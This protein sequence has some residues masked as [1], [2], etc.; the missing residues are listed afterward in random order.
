M[1][2]NLEKT[3]TTAISKKLV[4]LRNEVGSMT[5]GRVMT[6]V[7]LVDED[8]VDEAVNVA[9]EATRLHPSRIVV[10]VSDPDSSEPMLNAQIRLGGDAGASEIIVMELHGEL[11]EHPAAAL[12]P[13]LLADSPVVAWWPTP[14][15]ENI[16]D[17]LI[18]R[19]AQRRI[20]D[21]SVSDDPRG[22]IL[23][24]AFAYTSGDTDM[25]WARTT[26]WRGVLAGTLDTAPF[27][28]VEKA[29][30]VGAD[31][32]ASTDL[33]SGWLAVQLQCPVER[34]V[35]RHGVGLIS[36][37]LHRPSG[38]TVL[39]RDGDLATLKQ[40]GHPDRQMALPRP[41][42]VASLSEELRRLDK[43]EV[44]RDA[45]VRGL[46]MVIADGDDPVDEVLIDG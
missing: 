23:R 3:T 46:P 39:T 29:V 40:P 1:I 28:P 19:V 38:V 8:R 32:S 13:L 44:Y 31:D 22:E 35:S 41:D 24:R 4:Q 11:A 26:R 12:T 42:A 16:G 43:D 5:I 7:V 2:V 18:G 37:E 45:L 36:V 21:A 30:V 27:E 9:A 6:L 14:S 10:I 20:T 17:T 33:L 15:D 25:A 34:Q